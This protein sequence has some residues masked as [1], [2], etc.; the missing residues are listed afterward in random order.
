MMRW[1][2]AL[3]AV[4]VLSSL[5]LSACA[6]EP[7][8]ASTT[9]VVVVD[10]YWYDDDFW[11]WLDDDDDCCPDGDDLRDRIEEWWGDLSDAQKEVVKERVKDWLEDHEGFFEEGTLV[12]YEL[13]RDTVV[14]RWQALTPEE[15]QSWVDGRHERIAT[16][17][18]ELGPLSA[19]QQARFAALKENNV[20]PGTI[21]RSRLPEFG[22]RNP[23]A[24]PRIVHHPSPRGGFGGR[25]GGFGGRGGG[26][27]GGGRR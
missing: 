5:G 14:E 11:I 10:D 6:P 7:Q 15:R 8:V 19:E 9:D 18:A 21:D 16:R 20:D 2:G 27:R 1:L 12:N 17:R 25:G 24:T 13:L 3:G 23:A 26:G 4:V 22:E